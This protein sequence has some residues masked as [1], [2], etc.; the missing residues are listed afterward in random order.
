M[1]KRPT[2]RDI[3][4]EAGV[5]DTT[6][7]LAFVQNSRISNYTRQRVLEIAKSLKY[8][9]NR[10]ARDLRYGQSKTI[11]FVVTDITDPF[12]SRM[13][14]S[15]ERISLRLGYNM[16]FAEHNW[17]PEREIKI[18][19]NLIENRALGVIMCFSEKTEESLNLI[20]QT[21]L[22]VVAVDTVPHFYKGPYVINDLVEAGRIAAK[23]LVEVGCRHPVFFNSHDSMATF[24]SF[25]IMLK[26]F[27]RFLQS[28]PVAFDDSSVINAGFDIDG[29][30]KGFKHLLG[31]R[32][33]FD[34]I[35][36]VNDLCALGAMEAAEKNGYRIGENLAIMGID[37]IELSGISRISLTSISQPYDEIIQLA[38]DA[39]IESIEQGK[40]CKIKK[41]LKP[42]LVTRNSTKLSNSK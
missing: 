15:A 22:Y 40:P 38:T 2:I 27:R 28:Q 5:S 13:I 11:G 29:G 18:I 35:F 36:C 32:K 6:V 16:L 3:A 31:T 23:H 24:S 14:R 42:I 26:G 41:S 4:R 33:P 37:N 34:G 10:L 30:V 20:E 25:Q 7:S 9:P 17:E 12:Y 19:S 1:E 39:L 8:F 21:N